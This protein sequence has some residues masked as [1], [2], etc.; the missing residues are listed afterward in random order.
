MRRK[1]LRKKKTVSEQITGIKVM[2][3]TFY[4]AALFSSDVAQFFP[5]LQHFF[6]Q[7][8]GAESL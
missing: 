2:V 6:L 5:P 8:K 3:S 4:V 1:S 7:G